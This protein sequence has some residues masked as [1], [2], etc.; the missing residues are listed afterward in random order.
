MMCYEDKMEE[1]I[2][3]RRLGWKNVILVLAHRISVMPR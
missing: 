2:K 3:T 1:K